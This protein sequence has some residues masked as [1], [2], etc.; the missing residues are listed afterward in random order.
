MAVS[1]QGMQ[2]HVGAKSANWLASWQA[3]QLCCQPRFQ[4]HEVKAVKITGENCKRGCTP[5]FPSRSAKAME[6]G[7]VDGWHTSVLTPVN[8][9][10]YAKQYE[11]KDAEAQTTYT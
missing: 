6:W 2:D 4:F 8:E 10:V 3:G 9:D 7:E 5:T 1:S 11:N